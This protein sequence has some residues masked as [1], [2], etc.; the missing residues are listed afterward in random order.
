MVFAVRARSGFHIRACGGQ[1]GTDLD[2]LVRLKIRFLL[3]P[4]H[5]VCY[6]AYQ[7]EGWKIQPMTII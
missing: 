4:S 1:S 3:P 2:C 5:F 6:R 7:A